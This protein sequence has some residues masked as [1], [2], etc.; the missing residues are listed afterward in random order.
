[1][2][3]FSE[4]HKKYIG[5]PRKIICGLEKFLIEKMVKENPEAF[6]AVENLQLDIIV[7]EDG[8]AK[9]ITRIKET[10]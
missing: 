2:G 3:D 9:A 7:D 1:M 10:E 5:D 6:Q 4:E 8:K